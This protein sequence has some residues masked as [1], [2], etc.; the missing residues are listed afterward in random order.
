MN[1]FSTEATGGVNEHATR[2]YDALAVA[3]DPDA[4]RRLIDVAIVTSFI[5][6]DREE[7][8]FVIF[9]KEMNSRGKQTKLHELDR[10]QKLGIKRV[11]FA[12]IDSSLTHKNR[13]PAD[14]LIALART[15]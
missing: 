2:I 10:S 7:E 3:E 4:C 1:Q 8:A 14:L 13:T 11:S 6:S 5:L 15:V 12:S 9:D